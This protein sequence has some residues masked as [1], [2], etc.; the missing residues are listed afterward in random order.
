MYIEKFETIRSHPKDLGKRVILMTDLDG[1]LMDANTFTYEAIKATVKEYLAGGINIILNSSKTAAE[2]DHLCHEFD[3]SFTYICE[4][5]AA[6]RNLDTIDQGDPNPNEFQTIR[7]KPIAEIKAIWNEKVPS[8]LRDS[9]EFIGE[10][11]RRKQISLLGLYGSE[12]DRAMKREYSEPLVF[13]GDD[14]SFIQL[15]EACQSVGL[16]INRG[17]RVCNLSA[18]HDKSSFTR[19]LRSLKRYEE[20]PAYIIALGDAPNDIPMLEAADV[21]C[22]I[23]SKTNRSPMPRLSDRCSKTVI[24]SKSPAPKGWSEATEAALG[25]FLEVTQK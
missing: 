11:P 12:L 7:G 17:G 19:A 14:Q 9:C 16:R 6:I 10:M 22:I 2:M 25:Y 24:R 21:A 20:N 4:N 1:T 23:P 5:G 8:L 3:Y 13:S 18:E 15:L